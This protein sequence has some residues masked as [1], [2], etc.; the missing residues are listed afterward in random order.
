MALLKK[1]HDIERMKPYIK[2]TSAPDFYARLRFKAYYICDAENP[3]VN[4]KHLRFKCDVCGAKT[5]RT[6]DRYVRNRW[7]CAEFLCTECG[8]KFEGRV[9]FRKTY[10][11]VLVK[12]KICEIKK[13]TEED[14]KDE[15]QSLPE[16]V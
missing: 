6:T 11:D 16:T 9:S 5:K 12:S 10:D 8:R 7:I 3:L 2:D 1:H 4:R 13:K 15:M 14:K